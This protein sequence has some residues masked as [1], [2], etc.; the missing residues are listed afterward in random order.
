[1][2]KTSP[3]SLSCYYLRRDGCRLKMGKHSGRD[4]DSRHKAARSPFRRWFQRLSALWHFYKAHV[5]L[6]WQRDRQAL[7][8]FEAAMR[9]DETDPF[10]RVHYALVQSRR[11][12]SDALNQ[13]VASLS[14][15]TCPNGVRTLIG[16]AQLN[17]GR[18]RAAE[19]TFRK[20]L[21][22]SP[23]N[24]VARTGLALALGE[25]SQLREMI[26]LLEATPVADDWDLQARLAF[27][28]E[29]FLIG[30][31]RDQ[32][33]AEALLPKAFAC[34]VI[35][36]LTFRFLMW[37]G[38]RALEGG[39]WMKAQSLFDQAER[40][41]P[42]DFWALL[43]RAVALTEAGYPDAAQEALRKVPSDRQEVQAVKAMALIRQGRMANGLSLI[44]RLSLELPL[45]VYYE[46]VGSAL[47][48]EPQEVW[49]PLV[50]EIY[51]SD[52]SFLASRVKEL[53]RAVKPFL[54]DN[55]GDPA[56]VSGQQ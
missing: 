6:A 45:L 4:G 46:A 3:P 23:Y 34:P 42:G 16:R 55:R 27:L 54:S 38:G 19:R 15:G 24:L 20:V 5:L 33:L 40:L 53:V 8:S 50:S 43:L 48:G 18:W 25:S 56:S 41:R 1:M 2:A 10:A 29:R 39:D 11:S 37:R 44:R 12:R 36:R 9:S 17:L 30:K 7:V 47:M 31:Q 22:T 13:A 51:H 52:P 21:S 35:S 14:S 26:Q 49:A 28:L 32:P